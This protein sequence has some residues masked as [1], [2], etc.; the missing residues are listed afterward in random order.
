MIFAVFVRIGGERKVGNSKSLPGILE[1]MA[2]KELFRPA[3]ERLSFEMRQLGVRT[4]EKAWKIELKGGENLEI[5]RQY[6]REGSLLVIFNHLFSGDVFCGGAVLLGNFQEE[7][8]RLVI[9]GAKKHLDLGRGLKNFWN[10]KEM[11]RNEAL[12][13]VRDAIATKLIAKLTNTEII[14][15]VQSHDTDYYGDKEALSS[16]MNLLRRGKERLRTKGT[17][18]L[19]APEGHRSDDGRLQPARR[20]M[21]D[22]LEI[23]GDN[24]LCLPLGIAIINGDS[25]QGLMFGRR[26]RVQVG[27]PFKLSDYHDR[28][29]KRRLSK[30][31]KEMIATKIM[32]EQIAP[33]LPTS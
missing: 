21:V 9:P 33:L 13:L 16:W 19:F 2:I 31:E 23:G 28:E 8:K 18:M 5:A 11:E 20:G 32:V 17:V 14:H 15:I 26:V 27:E 3:I 12:K 1:K 29:K 10:E 6:L 7:T 25:G 30:Q 4:A 24:C 22:L